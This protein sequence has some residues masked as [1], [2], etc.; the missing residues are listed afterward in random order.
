MF[1]DITPH[2]VVATKDL[3]AARAFYED[4]LGLRV[5]QEFD[6]GM[7]LFLSGSAHVLV[8]LSDFAGTNQATAFGWETEDV[9]AV[10]SS[11]KDKGLEPMTFE[12]PDLQWDGGVAT[13]PDGSKSAWFSDPDGNIF[14]VS[15]IIG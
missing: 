3:A 15:S 7:V 9:A 5:K 12:A 2:V 1:A 10:V 6:E 11:L 4:V 13:M 8:Y 14:A